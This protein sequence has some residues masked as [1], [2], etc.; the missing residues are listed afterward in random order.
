MVKGRIRI[1][2]IGR[3]T[4][5]FTLVELLVT[6]GLISLVLAFSI[7]RF[8]YAVVPDDEQAVYQRFTDLSSLLRLKAVSEHKRCFLYID[9]NA[10]RIWTSD[11]QMS[12]EE[13]LYAAE[14]GYLLPKEIRIEAIDL[15]NR[16]SIIQGIGK[17]S[18]Y[19]DGYADPAYI[20]LNKK[21]KQRYSIFI[22][23]FLKKV[24]WH[25]KSTIR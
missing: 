1:S 20:H 2:R 3:S 25:E 22:E 10:S 11:E 6:L 16:K 17:I 13:L 18:Y 5:G 7:P 23:P 12:P 8:Q 9:M 14:N 19:P 24:T 21:G 4:N 15:P